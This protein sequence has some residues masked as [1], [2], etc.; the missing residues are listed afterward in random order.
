MSVAKI[1]EITSTSKTSFEDAVADGIKRASKTIR[2]ISGAWVADQEVVVKSGKI[3][4]YK[5]RL[6]LTF[7]LD[8]KK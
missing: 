7:V 5:V 8:N 3:V 4:E 6:R 2:D 1:S